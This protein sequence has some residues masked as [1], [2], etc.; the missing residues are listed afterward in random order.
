MKRAA[1]VLL[2]PLMLAGQPNLVKEVAPGV[3]YR[4]AEPEKGIIATSGWVVM[5]D[6]VM[7]IDANFPWGARALLADLR[8]TTDKP[9]RYVFNTHYHGDHSFGNSVMVDAGATVICSEECTDESE[10]LNTASWNSNNQPGEYSLQPFRLEHPQI[11][12]R[13]KLV[14]DDGARRVELLRV[15]PGH[16]R[17]DAVAYLPKER[18]LFTGDL[19]VSR[20]GNFVG[21]PGADPDN[22]VRALDSLAQKDVAIVVPGH[23]G[24]GTVDTLRGQRAYLADMIAQVRAGIARGASSEQLEKEIDLSRHNPW[25]QDR[26]R[27]RVSIR[28]F[29]A[30]LSK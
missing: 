15:G 6:S 28:A 18:V 16:T 20:A 19:A 24:Q 3:F 10:K 30:R 9:I 4:E 25:G 14:F 13:D 23:G 22:W 12:F 11:R 8:K 1:I 21:D 17:G 7:V 2:I 27:N 5:R 26:E 29:Y